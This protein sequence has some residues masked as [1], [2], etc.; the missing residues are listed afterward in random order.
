MEDFV[1]NAI[2]TLNDKSINNIIDDIEQLLRCPTSFQLLN[3][4]VV[5]DDGNVYEHIVIS[6]N[7]ESYDKRSP[8]TREQITDNFRVVNN[9][10]DMVNNLITI[11]PDLKDEIFFVDFS[12]T[13]NKSAILKLLSTRNHAKLK[14]YNDFVLFDKVNTCGCGN[15]NNTV[16]I[17]QLLSHKVS[18]DILSH[19][20]YN[21][22]DIDQIGSN[23][24]V[25]ELEHY[26]CANSKDK[27][28]VD[29]L[30]KKNYPFT[31]YDK[32]FYPPLITAYLNNNTIIINALK[33]HG[34]SL[35]S[36]NT[37]NTQVITKL[38]DDKT[39][40]SLKVI[41]IFIAEGLSFNKPIY[42][43]MNM[44]NYACKNTHDKLILS[45]FDI[46]KNIHEEEL[47]DPT[48]L[49][50]YIANG[51]EN[52]TVLKLLMNL[53]EITS[54]NINALFTTAINKFN[55][56]LMD[57]L[58][59]NINMKFI[60]PNN[61]FNR[62]ILLNAPLYMFQYFVDKHVNIIP[63]INTLK[64]N[65]SLLFIAAT[66]K[67]YDLVAYLMTYQI[68]MGPKNLQP[69]LMELITNDESYKSK[70]SYS[71]INKYNNKKNY[72]TSLESESNDIL[73]TYIITGLLNMGCTIN[74]KIVSYA[75]ARNDQDIM[76]IIVKHIINNTEDLDIKIGGKKLIHNILETV[77]DFEIIKTCVDK[78]PHL[79]YPDEKK[80]YPIHYA[81]RYQTND[82][83]IKY[84]ID[85]T[86]SIGIEECV[87]SQGYGA[88]HFACLYSTRNII[89]YLALDNKLDINGSV[90]GN[91]NNNNYSCFNLV[92]S[93]S[94]LSPVD[95]EMVVD[96]FCGILF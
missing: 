24:V 22:V 86:I 92:E 16:F 58:L 39:D 79:N 89:C 30:L 9:F 42:D 10:K 61:I 54:I 3:N 51:G 41:K 67:R 75:N 88:M 20:I 12:Y 77:N 8:L 64:Y 35:R 94:K 36:F 28:I 47:Y 49:R 78:L 81:L 17:A 93:N 62:L 19:V 2:K 95:K 46:I 55:T 96:M 25:S 5:A 91:V 11:R 7:Y 14:K 13:G 72:R 34:L 76:R 21:S 15:C 60:I 73:P 50:M 66:L 48:Q 31:C 38:I 27:K 63:L 83:I 90:P 44:L 32:N 23:P 71:Y 53:Y 1:T 82:D 84:I 59:L 57:I 29:Y 65:K 4:P 45:L 80:W 70:K 68:T 18:S 43:G 33:K 40:A 85:K 87:N 56:D 37:K 26:I 6:D 69:I 52:T 74:D